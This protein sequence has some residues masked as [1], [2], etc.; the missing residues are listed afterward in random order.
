MN[1]ENHLTN[2]GAYLEMANLKIDN[3]DYDSTLAALAK[4]YSNIRQAMDH[5][6]E[7]KRESSLH[8]IS[9]LPYT[10]TP[11]EGLHDPGSSSNRSAGE[12]TGGP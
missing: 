2:A 11:L 7:M 10:E 9:E 12:N 3:L 5:V 6:L 1:I 4:V 8:N